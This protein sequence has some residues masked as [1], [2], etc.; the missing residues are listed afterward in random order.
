MHRL[1]VQVSVKLRYNTSENPGIDRTAYARGQSINSAMTQTRSQP[2]KMRF[3]FVMYI[4]QLPVA[5]SLLYATFPVGSEITN[6]T[7]SPIITGTVCR[8]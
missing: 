2:G 5:S 4:D 8:I 3:E 6:S 7:L 1:C